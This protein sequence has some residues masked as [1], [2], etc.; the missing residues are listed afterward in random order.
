MN[1]NLWKAEGKTKDL[2][3]KSN[4]QGLGKAKLDN[5]LFGKENG[6]KKI[7]EGKSKEIFQIYRIL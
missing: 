7:R 1:Q 3:G 2:F 6:K 5:N 4:M